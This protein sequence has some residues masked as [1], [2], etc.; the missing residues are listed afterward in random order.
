MRQM[1]AVLFSS[2]QPLPT[3][4]ANEKFCEERPFASGAAWQ[5]TVCLGAGGMRRDEGLTEG[6]CMCVA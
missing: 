6:V 4:F 3:S 1:K 2:A 5:H